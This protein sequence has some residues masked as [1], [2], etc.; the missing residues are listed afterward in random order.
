MF[1]RKLKEF[2]F[3]CLQQSVWI[4][5]YPC[6]EE[7][8]LLREFLGLNKKQ[9]QVLEVIKLENEAFFKKIFKL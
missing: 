7:I 2:G 1:R 4:I 3:Y 9:I 5:P 8:E 6:Q